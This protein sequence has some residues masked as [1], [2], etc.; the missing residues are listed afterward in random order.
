MTARIALA[1][2]IVVA[3]NGHEVDERELAGAQVRL[4]LAMLVC[5]RDRAVAR[6]ELATN[7]WSGERPR[8][9]E[10]ALRGLVSRVR[11]VFV[12][13]GLGDR[14]TV[15]R[16]GPG[17]YRA[18][19]PADTVVDVE[20]AL[21]D[22][23]DA[24]AALR[25]GEVA[26]AAGH[27]ARGRAVLER[28][29]LPGVDAPWLDAQRATLTHATVRC[30]EA[31][32]AARLALGEPDH[33]V[34]AA[35]RATTVDPFRESAYRLLMRAHRAAG[36]PSAALRAYER[37]RRRLAEELGVDP[38][39]PTQALHLDLLREEHRPVA[40]APTP[41]ST[42]EASE[43][44]NGGG[45]YRGLRSFTEDDAPVFFGRGAD[46]ARMLERLAAQPF[47]AVLG[48]SGC[49]KSSLV[50]AGLVPALRRGALPSAD[51]WAIRVL[52]PGRDPLG[53]LAGELTGLDPDLTEEATCARLTA[54]SGTLDRVVQSVVGADAPPDR[55]I[56][57]VIDQLEEAFAPGVDATRRQAFLDALTA[58]VSTAGGRT[59]VVVTLRADLYPRL[60]EHPRFADLTSRQQLLLTAMDE[61]GLAEAI[62]GPARLAEVRTEPGLVETILGDVARRPGSLPLL[63]HCLLELWCRRG[64]DGLT[65]AAYRDTGGVE[66]ALAQRAEAVYQ[67]LSPA[68]RAATRRLLLRL[69]EPVEGAG[70]LRRR[71]PLAEILTPAEDAATAG[72]IVER[73][74][75]ARLLTTNGSPDGAAWVEISHEALVAGWPRLREWVEEGRS[76]LIVHRRLTNATEEWTRLGR[77]PDALHRGAQLAEACAWAERHPEAPNEQERAFLDASVA[78]EQLQRQRGLRRLRLAAAALSVGLAMVATL[79][80][81]AFLERERAEDQRELATSRQLA[82]QAANN[83]AVEPRRGLELAAAAVRVA[84]THEAVAALRQA[85]VTPTPRLELP[86][87]RGDL[88]ITPDRR[89]VAAL[90]EHDGTVQVRDVTDGAVLA[91]LADDAQGGL[92]ASFSPDGARLATTHEDGARIWDLAGDRDV[93]VLRHPTTVYGAA[94]SPDGRRVATASNTE[95][96]ELWDGVSGR[97]L[98]TLTAPTRPTFTRWTPNG[99]ALLAWSAVDPEVVL[100]DADSG[101]VLATLAH[102]GAVV[103]VELSPDGSHVAT[104]S[105][106]GT[107]GVWRLPEG[108][109]HPVELGPSLRV[110]GL[111]EAV[112]TVGFSPDGRLL[113]VGD[114]AGTVRVVDV[115]HGT[116]RFEE[117]G[118]ADQVID[119][120]FAPDGAL[121]ATASID[122]TALVWDLER[123]DVRGQLTLNGGVA[124]DVG[125]SSVAFAFDGASLVTRAA[126]LEVWE[127]PDGPVATIAAHE[128]AVR[129]LDVSADGALLATG[130]RDG[131]LRVWDRASGTATASTAVPDSHVTAVSFRPDGASV[132]AANPYQA[133]ISTQD[134][135]P[136]VYDVATGEPLLH[137][138]VPPAEQP[139]CPQL[140]Q[141]TAVA[142]SP[143]GRHILTAGQDGIVRLWEAGSG[144][145]AKTLEPSQ[146]RLSAATFDADGRRIAAAG[147]GG[148]SLWEVTSGESVGVLDV[149]SHDVAFSPDGTRLAVAGDDGVTSLWEAP[150]GERLADLRQPARVSSVAWHDDGR[151]VLTGGSDGAWLWDVATAQSLQHFPGATGSVAFAPDGDIL[152]GRNDGTVLAHRCEV[153][154]SVAELVDLARQ[155]TMSVAAGRRDGTAARGPQR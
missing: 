75:E 50:R 97:H 77:D 30:L 116:T 120:D 72:T 64:S 41:R 40:V 127:V 19:L 34:A 6:E 68:E 69:V 146:V 8:T 134:L 18:H 47:L 32:A 20:Q 12:A 123:G 119:A 49:G 141:T 2:R 150:T 25:K 44:A 90:R 58:A 53:A 86:G 60:A 61:V 23:D 95:A 109:P 99:A 102:D 15:V 55:R 14:E 138:E 56:V 106:D 113:V 105:L 91:D 147:L 112:W 140:C 121:V 117:R 62:T 79:A 35:E 67:T 46:V 29:L 142:F 148:V 104:A 114:G 36:N 92:T 51:T 93:R 88:A 126:A 9:W 82:A 81:L 115:E 98:R 132:A 24:D 131:T 111:A 76:G 37:C 54:D 16:A 42:R 135:P 145:L 137:I 80:V 151:F 31:L 5:E 7:L 130:G 48:S 124:S 94:W 96:L 139:P 136:A 129:S 28:P 70:D 122:G 103:D 65:L 84:P 89:H 110:D 13:T 154:G 125:R 83:L 27:A 26:L 1:G 133:T 87:G 152:L 71:V 108:G 101:E 33:A 100:L 74:A 43:V 4:V 143:A 85:L 144:G 52:R 107:A 21:H 63:S 57:F 118:H 73:L 155:R 59:V 66:G 39:L 78:R 22:V 45:P 3:H 10:T 17:T 153:C 11:G 128:G 38:A 149:P